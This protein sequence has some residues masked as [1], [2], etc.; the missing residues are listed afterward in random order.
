MMTKVRFSLGNSRRFL[1]GSIS[2]FLANLKFRVRVGKTKKSVHAFRG[3]KL[4]PP[5]HQLSTRRRSTA[6]DKPTSTHFGKTAP[7]F[8]TQKPHIQRAP[9][10]MAQEQDKFGPGTNDTLIFKTNNTDSFDQKDLSTHGGESDL[11]LYIQ[12]Y[13][14]G[15]VSPMLS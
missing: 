12:N 5:P 9:V 10:S 15:L 2:P 3:L 1:N 11:Y 8:G 4:P 7:L 13:A 6:N 14:K